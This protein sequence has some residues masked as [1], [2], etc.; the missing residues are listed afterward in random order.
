MGP[1]H[2]PVGPGPWDPVEEATEKGENHGEKDEKG[3]EDTKWAISCYITTCE[4][5]SNTGNAF[6]SR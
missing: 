2:G 3:R 4:N 5:T 6:E 1:G